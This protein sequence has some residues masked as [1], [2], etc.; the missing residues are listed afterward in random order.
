MNNYKWFAENLRMGALFICLSML[1]LTWTGFSLNGQSFENYTTEIPGTGVELDMVAIPGGAF[2]MGSPADEAGRS[3]DEGPRRQVQVDQFWMGKYEITWNQYDLFA[4][5][6]M[7]DLDTELA[8]ADQKEISITADALSTPTQPY[9]DM[10]FG[11]GRDGYPAISMTHYAAVMFAKWLTAKTGDFYRLPTEAEWEY[12][13]RG[14]TDTTY[15]FGNSAEEIEDHAWYAENSDRSYNKVGTKAP[16]PFGLYDMAGNLSEWT[17]DQYYDDYFER[18][19]DEPADNPWFKPTEL[20][21]R[22]V[23]GGSWEDDAKDQRCTNRF[24]SRAGWKQLDPQFPK[25]LW[26]HTSAPFVGFRLVRPAET[27]SP[28]EIEEYWIEAMDD[29]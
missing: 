22:S 13:C 17:M 7:D 4:N 25:S 11:M 6:V 2:M 28:E 24:G 5:E 10:T 18:L 14:G 15:Y 1:G 19:E 29:Y 21:P 9:V 27:P 12:A 3:G 26:W 8:S 20:Y 16:N 23:R